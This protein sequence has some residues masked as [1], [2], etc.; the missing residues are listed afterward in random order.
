MSANTFA[1][2][3]CNNLILLI[4]SG[5]N[6]ID[7]GKYVSALKDFAEKRPNYC[8]SSPF[9]EHLVYWMEGAL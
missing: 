4:L 8:C 2:E 9:H 7:L 1:F 5:L 6:V 3:D